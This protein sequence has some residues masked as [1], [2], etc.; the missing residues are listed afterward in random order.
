MVQSL[1]SVKGGIAGVEIVPLKLLPNDKGRLM[2]IQRAD[3]PEFLGFGQAYITS[4]YPGVI[5]AWYRHTRQIDQIAVIIGLLKL[6]LYDT[7]EN[8]PTYGKLDTIFLGELAPKLVQF[9]PGIW[10]GFQAI[11]DRE[12]FAVHLNSIAFQFDAPDEERL[13]IDTDLIPYRW[14]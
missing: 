7:R 2:E 5:K 10:H 3:S 6:V 13:P 14:S 4:T 1:E 11:G 8:S 9:P 12:T